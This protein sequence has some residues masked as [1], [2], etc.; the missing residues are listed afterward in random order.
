MGLSR[1]FVTSNG[2]WNMDQLKGVFLWFFMEGIKGPCKWSMSW[3]PSSLSHWPIRIYVKYLPAKKSKKHFGLLP[4]TMVSRESSYRACLSEHTS[5]YWLKQPPRKIQQSR[6]TNQQKLPLDCRNNG[7]PLNSSAKI[8][9][10]FWTSLCSWTPRWGIVREI[11]TSQ[12]G[13][14][15]FP[16]Q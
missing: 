1:S 13:Y 15:K 6:R 8:H 10:I 5:I 3:C 2:G 16:S 9:G 11:C 12:M 4:S 14:I 7:F